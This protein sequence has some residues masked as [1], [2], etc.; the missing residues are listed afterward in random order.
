MH[1]N[2]AG[3]LVPAAV[4]LVIH[5]QLAHNAVHLHKVWVEHLGYANLNHHDDASGLVRAAVQLVIHHQLAHN[6]VHLQKVWVRESGYVYLNSGKTL[7]QA[8]LGDVS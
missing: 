6:A 7:N 8:R 1:H 2:G 5:H 4:Q 3:G